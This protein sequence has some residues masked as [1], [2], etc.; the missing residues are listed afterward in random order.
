MMIKLARRKPLK[1]KVKIEK[2]MFVIVKFMRLN[3]T[4]LEGQDATVTLF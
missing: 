3:P 4:W 1:L 2:W